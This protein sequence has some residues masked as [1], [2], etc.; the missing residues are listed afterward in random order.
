MEEEID[1]YDLGWSQG[2]DDQLPE[3][4]YPDGTYEYIQFWKGYE[5]GS[6]DC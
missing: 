1:P 2:Y 6:N 3:C 5:Q 4:P